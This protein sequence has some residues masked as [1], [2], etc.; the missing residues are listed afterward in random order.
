L[1]NQTRW[2]LRFTNG[3]LGEYEHL[4]PTSRIEHVRSP[5]VSKGLCDLLKLTAIRAA[6]SLTV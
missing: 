1:I 3:L 4:A 6:P 2:L 5:R